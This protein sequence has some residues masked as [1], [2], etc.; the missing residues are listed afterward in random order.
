MALLAYSTNPTKLKKLIDS[1]FDELSLSQGVLSEAIRKMLSKRNPAITDLVVAQF[2]PFLHPSLFAFLNSAN[3]EIPL[4]QLLVGYL[5][6]ETLP[7][8]ITV[9]SDKDGVVYIPN[10][11]YLLTYVKNAIFTLELDEERRPYSLTHFSKSE[12]FVLQPLEFYDNSTIE[13]VKHCQPNYAQFF[14]LKSD[15][16][17]YI[18]S[19]RD[20]KITNLI[21]AFDLY[22]V[23]YNEL[24]KL[25]TKVGKQVLLFQHSTLRSFA[26][27]RAH[28]C[29]FINVMDND[30]EIFFL[31]EIAHQFG[32]NILNSIL[33]DTKRYLQIDAKTPLSA[34]NNNPEEYRSLWDALHG[35]FTTALIGYYFNRFIND[36]LYT[37]LKGYEV[38]ARFADNQRRVYTGLGKINYKQVFTDDGSNLF[39]PLME[40]CGNIFHEKNDLIK[41]FDLSGLPFVFDFEL[42]LKKNPYSN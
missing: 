33:T 8:S 38:K 12:Q 23:R 29:A 20:K 10:I 35:L 22:N 26:T 7:A 24:H 27:K 1:L 14:N 31:A 32:H 17:L 4:E 16:Q 9:K 42:F 19:I 25:I 21:S 40:A 36:N 37:G 41:G 15:E 30:N 18:E 3:P 34:L 28:G 13:I 2:A 5:K 11:G 39:L 6:P